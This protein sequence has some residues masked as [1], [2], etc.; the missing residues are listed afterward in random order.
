[1]ARIGLFGGDVTLAGG[2]LVEVEGGGLVDTSCGDVSGLRVNSCSASMSASSGESFS[3]RS[4][5][6]E[7]SD[8]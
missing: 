7:V 3:S 5:P 6:I 2:T 1:L 4:L 8:D